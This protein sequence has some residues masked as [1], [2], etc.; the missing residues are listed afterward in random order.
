MLRSAN[1]E[2]PYYAAFSSPL[3]LHPSY[4]LRT[5]FKHLQSIPPP[6][7]AIVPRESGPFSLLRLQDHTQRHSVTLLCT[8]DQQRP[9]LVPDNTQHSQETDIHAPSGIRT[10]NPNKQAATDSL[11]NLLAPKFYI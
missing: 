7:V 2:T 6:H 11:L 4:A 10:H 1:L 8:S 5:V 3:L 9:L